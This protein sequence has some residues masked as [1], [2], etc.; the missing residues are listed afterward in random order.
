VRG[1]ERIAL[2]LDD[3]ARAEV[4]AFTVYAWTLLPNHAPPWAAVSGPRPAPRPGPR[5]DPRTPLPPPP[6]V[7]LP[8]PADGRPRSPSDVTEK[9]IVIMQRPPF[10][11][12][13]LMQ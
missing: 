6:A 10:R 8:R 13:D 3:P 1:G 5:P 11:G 2:F 4:G 12:E 7:P 9:I